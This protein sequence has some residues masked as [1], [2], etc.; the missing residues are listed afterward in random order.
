MKA[1]TE[2]LPQ[3]L[4]GTDDAQKQE[5]ARDDAVVAAA[6]VI[7]GGRLRVPGAAISSPTAARD[8]LTLKL[9]S[10][11]HEVFCVLYLD[12]QHRVIDFQEVF[13]GTL[14]QTSVYPREILKEALARN[15]AAVILS[16]NHP[17]GIAEPSR[18][19]EALTLALKKAL[20]LIDVRI[21][22]HIVVAGSSTV[23]FAE[24]G[25]L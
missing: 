25:L 22:D 21:I 12:A 19:D 1:R 8:Y 10:L 24:R 17:S 4:P 14:T 9:A 23:S 16:H 15:A 18:A 6:L 13:R 20:A 3:Y 5:E 2:S 7:L 11:P